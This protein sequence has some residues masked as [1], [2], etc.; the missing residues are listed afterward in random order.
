VRSGI[1]SL[2]NAFIIQKALNIDKKATYSLMRCI[3]HFRLIFFVIGAEFMRTMADPRVA[4]KMQ[5]M[6]SI[7]ITTVLAGIHGYVSA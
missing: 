5:C 3:N 2:D 7:Q 1:S 6:H 4:A